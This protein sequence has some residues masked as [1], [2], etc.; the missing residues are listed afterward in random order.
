MIF[1]VIGS[2]KKSMSAEPISLSLDEASVK[3][4]ISSYNQ[5]GLSADAFAEKTGLCDKALLSYFN[6]AEAG[7]ATLKGCK[8]HIEDV[9]NSIGLMGVKA[10]ATT[11]IMT[12]LKAALNGII[13]GAIIALVSKF[14]QSLIDTIPTAKKIREEAEKAKENISDITNHLKEQQDTIEKV[15]KRYAELAQGVDQIS[16][17]NLTLSNDKYQEFLDISNQLAELFPSL[18]E[19]YDSNGNAILNLKGNVNDIVTSLD[20]LLKKE[21]EFS[22]KE[23]LDNL[24]QIYDDY[25]QKIDEYN[26]KLEDAKKRQESYSKLKER[27]L[28]PT[29][30]T[31]DKKN[32]TFSFVGLDDQTKQET[33][34][35]LLKNVDGVRNYLVRDIELLGQYTTQVT[36]SLD[37]AFKGFDNRLFSAHEDI[38]KYNN[39]IKKE[40]ASFNYYLN[41]L[42]QEYQDAD[43]LP[44]LQQLLSDTSWIELAREELGNKASF[45]DIVTWVE[46]EYIYALEKL[47]NDKYKNKLTKLFTD[48]LLPQEK[49]DLAKEI[50]QYFEENDIKISLGFIWD[51]KDDNSTQNL[52][53][54][55]NRSLTDRGQRS[56]PQI[57][58][59]K[60][61]TKDFTEEQMLI[62]L[63]VTE[64]IYGAKKAIAAY[65]EYF[66]QPKEEYT[67]FFTEENKEQV[68]KYIQ[69]VN[70]LIGYYEKLNTIEGLTK[71]DK[72]ELNEVYGIACDSSEEYEQRILGELS[73]LEQKDK[74][75]EIIRE[76]ISLCTNEQEKLRLTN[77]LDDLTSIDNE[78]MDI[79]SGF[80]NM[81]NAMSTLQSHATVVKN[82][83][84]DIKENSKISPD[85]LREIIS[86]YSDLED[87]ISLYVRGLISEEV[88]F[89]QLEEA[90]KEDENNYKKLIINKL[91]YTEDFYSNAVKSTPD[92]VE[93]M[94]KQYNIDFNQFK[95]VA[96]AKLELEKELQEKRLKLLQITESYDDAEEKL[97]KSGTPWTGFEELEMWGKLKKQAEEDVEKALELNKN[98]ETHLVTAVKTD[99]SYNT[100][101]KDEDKGSK[102]NKDK[103]YNTFD[104]SINWIDRN[105]EVQERKVKKAQ[106]K[107]KDNDPYEKQIHNLRETNKELSKYKDACQRASDAYGEMCSEESDDFKNLVAIVGEDKSKTY[108]EWI[109]NGKKGMNIQKIKDKELKSE[110]SSN[111]SDPD[112]NKTKGEKKYEA[113]NNLID[114]NNKQYDYQQ[115]VNET[116]EQIDQNNIKIAEKELEQVDKEIQLLEEKINDK[117]LGYTEKIQLYEQ[118]NDLLGQQHDKKIA[119]LK[120]TGTQ[121]DIDSENSQYQQKYNENLEE[122]VKLQDQLNNMSL[123]ELEQTEANLLSEMQMLEKMGGLL[124]FDQYELLIKGSQ[125]QQSIHENNIKAWQEEIKQYTIGSEKYNELLEKINAAGEAIN[126]CKENQ[127]EWNN[128][129]INLPIK[130]LEEQKSI[131]EQTST[132]LEKESES[133]NNLVNAFNFVIDKKIGDLEQAN[134][135]IDTITSMH[136]GA[137]NAANKILDDNISTLQQS[138]EDITVSYD[139]LISP[140]ESQLKLL[141]ETNEERSQALSLQKAQYELERAK[142]QKTVKVFKKGEGWVYENDAEEI[143]NKQNALDDALYNKKVYDLQK[144]IQALNDQKDLIF[145]GHDKHSGI[146]GQIEFYES[147]KKKYANIGSVWQDSWDL[148]Q[149]KLIFGD[150]FEKKILDGTFDPTLIS[151]VLLKY[152]NE[153]YINDQQ[154]AGLNNFKEVLSDIIS[155]TD[156]LNS[157]N[158]AMSEFNINI[159]NMVDS[160]DIVGLSKISK[161]YGNLNKKIINNQKEID[162]TN[163]EID[164][165]NLFISALDGTEQSFITCFNNIIS[166]LQMKN[167][168]LLKKIGLSDEKVQ[169]IITS[170][171]LLKT[172]VSEKGNEITAIVDTNTGKVSDSFVNMN[173]SVPASQKEFDGIMSDYI[174][175]AKNAAKKISGY[176]GNINSSLGGI[177]S[178]NVNI[179]NSS[180]IDPVKHHDGMKKGYVAE[181]SNSTFKK[182]F[183][184]LC[185]TPLEPNE[186]P[187]V[188]LKGEAVLTEKQQLQVLENFKRN[189]FIPCTPIGMKETKQTTA[190]NFNGDIIIKESNNAN[191]LANDIVRNLPQLMMQRLYEK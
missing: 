156:G 141:Q 71:K 138:M 75:I 33:I 136:Q 57:E 131:L 85:N 116:Q 2:I 179:Q 42:L 107:I 173:N 87:V 139:K 164:A 18:T 93:D 39:L 185:L 17:E 47:N 166:Y 82:V 145:Y 100:W 170:T 127:I 152:G 74:I 110:D 187:I 92:W 64:G 44:I 46:E 129:I 169:E 73:V 70:D 120:L 115:K 60:E 89:E 168:D 76:S 5:M 101:G 62:W 23:T 155:N 7:S 171:K 80:E 4:I 56:L 50:Q 154:I 158:K 63:D 109:R 22:R 1:D 104:N 167:P 95:S 61:F 91:Q 77:L 108:L 105:I 27:F 9:N 8:V 24:P 65:N 191:N 84:K 133:Y 10:K 94:N 122:Q 189:S 143:K 184:R 97:Y 3:K 13:T 144:Q 137:L 30:E 147:Q 172:T 55:F 79:I 99:T 83:L 25:I 161:E 176:L 178:I 34:N 180:E 188:A 40:T 14:V 21:Q 58:E 159:S 11:I 174:K 106:D 160:Y 96:E 48:P 86:A 151:D 45:D 132:S 54:R 67:S 112:A 149:A 66:N 68:D 72:I 102:G 183:E 51:E 19:N 140:L 16:G 37:K 157:L 135:Y 128:A 29:Y 119:L 78:S 98:F 165:L 15:K 111:S 153:K 41:M 182:Q 130:Y 162:S 90:Y 125:L 103:N 113:I 114:Y 6:T 28:N 181:R 142:N 177:P 118:L 126:K 186:F 36:L 117:N 150:D 49:V 163:E 134:D 12:G 146:Q 38:V 32:V 190:V 52:L 123:N 26:N 35:Y 81:N 124:S 20:N 59:L 175:S 148:E 69:K 121:E 31:A 53:A 43:I 88:L